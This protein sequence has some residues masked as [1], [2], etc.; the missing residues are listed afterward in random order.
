[1]SVDK[2]QATKVVQN[3]FLVCNVYALNLDLYNFSQPFVGFSFGQHTAQLSSGAILQSKP[4][5]HG[6][7]PLPQYQSSPLL[8]FFGFLQGGNAVNIATK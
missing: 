7:P 3:L 1:M 4:S 8:S 5:G 2:K 6:V